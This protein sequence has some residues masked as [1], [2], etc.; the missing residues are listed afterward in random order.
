MEGLNHLAEV[1]TTYLWFEMLDGDIIEELAALN[2]LH[3]DVCNRDL[4]AIRL[5]FECVSFERKAS[6]NILVLQINEDLDFCLKFAEH[7]G[8]IKWVQ[9]VKHFDCHFVAVR[10]CG[11]LYF[12][13]DARSER[14][15]CR[16]LVN[17]VRHY[18]Y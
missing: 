3:H 8:I 1:V 17:F 18:Y 14:S 9:F 10:T 7:L 6:N 16:V 11:Q 2:Q 13:R 12:G 5:D 4:A 15:D